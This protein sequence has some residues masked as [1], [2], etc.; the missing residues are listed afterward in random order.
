LTEEEAI[1]FIRNRDLKNV[2]LTFAEDPNIRVVNGRYGPYLTNGTDNYKIPKDMIANRMS[3]AECV[4]IME[5][6]AP[7]AKKRAVTRKR[8]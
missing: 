8:K 1:D 6:T 2:L 7:T 5:E 3:Y 4:K